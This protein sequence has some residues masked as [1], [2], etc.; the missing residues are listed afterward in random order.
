MHIYT[1]Y[2]IIHIHVYILYMSVFLI[3]S[4]IDDAGCFLALASVNN[5]AVN[6][7]VRY[8]FK[9]VFLYP[10]DKYPKVELLDH[11]IVLFLIL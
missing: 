2:I 5:I 9:L 6:M 10:S 4:S 1:L 7:G 11:I 8:L 3:H